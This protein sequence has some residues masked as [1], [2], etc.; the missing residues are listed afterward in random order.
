MEEFMTLSILLNSSPYLDTLL[1]F[2]NLKNSI[3]LLIFE[4]LYGKMIS[5]G[6]Y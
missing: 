2:E 5:K 6:V 4:V 3:I 1:N